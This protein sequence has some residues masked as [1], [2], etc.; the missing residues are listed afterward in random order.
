MHVKRAIVAPHMDDE[1]LG[2]GGLLAKYPSE[3]GVIVIAR[4]D[5]VRSK[6]FEAA[7]EILGYTVTAFLDK[8]DGYINAD[9]HDLVGKLDCV[10]AD[11]TP[12]ELYVPYPS[13]HQDHIATYEAGIRAGRLSMS[14]G[15]H[16][17]P[18]VY[19]YDVAVYDLDLFPT[20]LKWN[21]NEPLNEEQIDKKVAALACYGSQAVTGPHPVNGIKNLAQAIGN[22]CAVDWAERF[23][24]VRKVRK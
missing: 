2:C 3:C 17:T 13:M 6:E 21:I 24:L 15:H 22:A 11:W 19:V 23:A 14:R 8:E 4:P 9:M 20:E 5:D 16:F 10:L 12:D 7:R 18:S 1:T